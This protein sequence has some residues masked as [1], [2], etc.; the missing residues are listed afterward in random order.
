LYILEKFPEAPYTIVVYTDPIPLPC[1][2]LGFLPNHTYQNTPCLNTYGQPEA[3]GFGYETLPQFPFRPQPIEV[4]P[5][6]AT[7]EPGIDPNN[8]T[9]QLATVLREYFNIEPKGR[10]YVYQK[11]YPN[12]YD[13]LLYPRGYR[14]LEF[15]KFSGEDG[16]STLE[17]V[18]Q[19]ILQCGE[20]SANDA[21]KLKMFPLCLSGTTFTWFTSLAPNSILTWAQLEHKFYEYFYSGDTKLRLSHLTAIT[22]KHNEPIADYIRRFRDI[23][24][25]CF[26]LHISNKD[27]T[28]LAYSG[29]LSHLREKLESHVFFDVS[30]VLQ[31][32]LDCKSRAKESRS[33]TRSGDKPRIDCPINVV[34]YGSKSSDDDEADM[35]VAEWSW[36]SKSKPFI[37]SS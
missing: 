14:V 20:A 29:L 15:S 12:Y 13:Q 11:P 35:C 7:T 21:L 2:F 19:S 24:N 27:L 3:G 17:H 37:C 25:Q 36:A 18:G 5:T 26:N 28:D 9:N 30:L 31:K 22:Q 4:T 32:A 33:A 8:L 16:K 1:S 34:E 6:R 23:R 10:G